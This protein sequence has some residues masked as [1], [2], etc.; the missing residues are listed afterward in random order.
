MIRRVV[1]FVSAAALA[2]CQS[3]R[4]RETIPRDGTRWLV[5]DQVSP[6]TKTARELR[7]RTARSY[8]TND[9]SSW[10]QY[11]RQPREAAERWGRL[12]EPF[13]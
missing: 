10:S 6:P 2:G 1:V 7:A 5:R 4:P 3:A 12:A 11:L 8:F 9:G 13:E